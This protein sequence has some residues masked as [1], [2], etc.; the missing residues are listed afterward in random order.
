MKLCEV[1]IVLLVFYLNKY[2]DMFKLIAFDMDGTLTPSKSQ[3]DAQMVEL[4]LKLLARYKV[5]IISG[6]DYPQFQKQVLAFL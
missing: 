3:M 2:I 6:G 1:I 4:L 5:A